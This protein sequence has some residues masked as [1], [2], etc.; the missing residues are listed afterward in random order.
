MPEVKIP[1]EKF[2]PC[3]SPLISSG[4][5]REQPLPGFN[6]EEAACNSL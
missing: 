5:K 1:P 3:H 2:M 6:Q 4:A